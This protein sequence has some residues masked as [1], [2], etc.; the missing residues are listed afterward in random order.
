MGTLD[1]G[2]TITGI[3]PAFTELVK[4]KVD[5]LQDPHVLQL[6]TVG[7]RSIIK[8]GADILVTVANVK[9]T[10]YMDIANFDRYDMIIGTPWMRKSMETLHALYNSTKETEP[11]REPTYWTTQAG[12]EDSPLMED[13]IPRLRQQWYERFKDILQETPEQLS[14]LRNINH[15]INLVDPDKRYTHWLPTCPVPLRPHFYEKLNCY[16]DAGWWKKHSA[17]QAAPLMCIPKKDKQLQTIIDARQQN[18]NTVKDVTPLPD[19]DII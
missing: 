6:G 11:K 16:V 15:E 12:N 17:S 5:T 10:S 13:D 18:N 9:T 2:S 8:Y 3:T 7:S 19:Q 1:S 14:P 4:V